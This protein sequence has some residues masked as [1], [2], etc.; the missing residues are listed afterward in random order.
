MSD[1]QKDLDEY[2]VT[3]LLHRLVGK[4]VQGSFTAVSSKEV[5]DRLRVWEK[6]YERVY[7]DFM[8]YRWSMDLPSGCM[9]EEEGYQKYTAVLQAE[10]PGLEIEALRRLQR[11]MYH[12]LVER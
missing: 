4:P 10:F 2:I 6:L 12:Y 7:G 3:R 5:D 9:R 8:K 1:A 11:M